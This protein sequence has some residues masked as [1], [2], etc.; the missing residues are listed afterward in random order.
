MDPTCNILSKTINSVIYISFEFGSFTLSF[1][2]QINGLALYDWD[3]HP[4]RI[5]P[6]FF[7]KIIGVLTPSPL[8]VLVYYKH[9]LYYEK[10]LVSVFSIVNIMGFN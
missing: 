8:N 4:E 1:A 3:L 6:L 7:Y 9:M 10:K 2:L 5:E